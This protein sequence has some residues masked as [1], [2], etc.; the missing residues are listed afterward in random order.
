MWHGEACGTAGPEGREVRRRFQRE[1]R[2][3]RYPGGFWRYFTGGLAFAA[4]G[5]YLESTDVP[6]YLHPV[7]AAFLGLLPLMVLD[8]FG[9]IAANFLDERR[10]RR[11]MVPGARVN[12]LFLAV[13][14]ALTST[15]CGLLGWADGAWAT[16]TS[17]GQDWITTGL[18]WGMV[19][20]ACAS[21]ML[22]GRAIPAGTGRRLAWLTGGVGAGGGAGGSGGG[23]GV[24]GVRRSGGNGV[25]AGGGADGFRGG[26]G[27]LDMVAGVAGAAAGVG[28]VSDVFG[29]GGVSG[30]GGVVGY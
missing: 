4:A 26:V 1:R 6:G 25:G 30:T 11:G 2:R 27:G 8:I 9:T 22:V 13:G 15:A 10:A 17:A 18:I 23:V 12:F 24:A 16:G 21:I 3:R 29:V 14:W 20:S 7:Q 28:V 5:G 19:I